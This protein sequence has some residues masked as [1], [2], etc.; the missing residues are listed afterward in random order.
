VTQKPVSYTCTLRYILDLKR[1]TSVL[2]SF[3]L[4]TAHMPMPAPKEAG[5]RCIGTSMTHTWA[6]FVPYRRIAKML[7]PGIP[8]HSTPLAWALDN[9]YLEFVWVLLKYGSNWRAR[10]RQDMTPLHRA[11]EKGLVAVCQ[12]IIDSG[13]DAKER[14]DHG[15]VPLHWASE[16]GHLE[17]VRFLLAHDA[18]V[19][20]CDNSNKTPL[21]WA[22]DNGHLE[23]AR[24]SSRTV[25]M[26]IP[27]T[28][29]TRHRCIGRRIM[30]I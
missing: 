16:N 19:D 1:D 28:N 11:S 25:Q 7:M 15:K 10:D 8:A 12:F 23:V 29:P 20:S 4:Q 30:G 14:D 5:P 26:S 21:R 6:M 27:V 18:D 9:E 13:A 2:Y 3:V 22:S 17:V 24:S